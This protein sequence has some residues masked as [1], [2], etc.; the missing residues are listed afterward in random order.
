MRAPNK[1]RFDKVI[2][3]IGE[4]IQGASDGKW[5]T[6]YGEWSTL[7]GKRHSLGAEDDLRA[8]IRCLRELDREV[9][10]RGALK[11]RTPFRGKQQENIEDFKAVR[12]QVEG[13]QKALKKISSQA[14]FLI[15]SGAEDD[16]HS[17]DVPSNEIM[18]PF[19]HRFQQVTAA[20]TYM[21][22][23][24][25]FLLDERPGQHGSTDFRQRRVAVESWRLLRCLGIEPKGGTIDSLYGSITSLLW[26]A[27]TG[28]PTKDLQRACKA[29]LSQANKGS[30][31]DGN[32]VIGRGSIPLS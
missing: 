26:E 29:T 13:L 31:R 25:D 3:E 10:Y 5:S 6:L 15:F 7:D 24:C 8:T 14:R 9:S 21:R 27:V 16:V 22:D 32:R 30:L 20:L 4:K 23:R 17:D 28:E 18:W 1:S 11:K 12:K 2:K 19:L